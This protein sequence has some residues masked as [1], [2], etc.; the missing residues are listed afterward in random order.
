MTVMR[1]L[2]EL[3]NLREQLENVAIENERYIHEISRLRHR[4][5][6]GMLGEHPEMIRLHELISYV[7]KTDVTVLIQAE[8]GCGKEVVANEIQRQSQRRDKALF[9]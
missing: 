6:T 4:G 5:E 7:A 1:D 9:R 2:T 8:T 3:L